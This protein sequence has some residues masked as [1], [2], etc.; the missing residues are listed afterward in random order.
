[1]YKAETDDVVIAEDCQYCQEKVIEKFEDHYVIDNEKPT[2][3]TC[4][5]IL[6]RRRRPALWLRGATR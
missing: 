6:R 1:M 5:N 2:Q 3:K 4:K